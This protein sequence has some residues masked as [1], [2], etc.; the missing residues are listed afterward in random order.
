M[1][2]YSRGIFDWLKDDGKKLVYEHDL[3][4]NSTIV[5]VGGYIGSWAV[6][7]IEKYHCNICIY[8]PVYK[9]FNLLE[10]NIALYDKV[11]IYNYGLGNCNQ[12]IKI[13]HRGVQTTT[14]QTHEKIYDEII[15]IRDIADENHLIDSKIDLMNINIEGGEYELLDRIIDTK[16]I[17][18]IIN[19]QVQFH[20]WYPSYRKSVH[21]RDSLH[22]RLKITH[23]LTYCYPFVWEN[24]KIKSYENNN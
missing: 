20:E 17:E 15:E 5:D 13:Q 23:K 4:Q 6:K 12:K 9:Y 21:L 16:M 24:W 10:T 3:D 11:D 1:F 19:I 7:M 22:N 18:N 8:E 14:Q 2:N